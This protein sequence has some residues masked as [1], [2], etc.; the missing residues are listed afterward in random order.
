MQ[1]FLKLIRKLWMRIKV[2][3]I[4]IS[5]DSGAT[6]ASIVRENVL[7]KRERILKDKKNKWSTMAVA[8]LILL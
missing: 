7:Y 1:Q 8:V 6:S 2:F 3:T 5:L 4:K